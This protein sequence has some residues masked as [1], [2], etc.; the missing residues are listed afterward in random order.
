MPRIRPQRTRKLRGSRAR[1]WAGLS[2]FAQGLL[3]CTA[4]ESSADTLGSVG[5]SSFEPDPRSDT[6]RRP[7]A[8][9]NRACSRTNEPSEALGST[10]NGSIDESSLLADAGRTP[11]MLRAERDAGSAVPADAEPSSANEAPLD[12]QGPGEFAGVGGEGCFVWIAELE[13]WAAARAACADWG[14]ALARV[15]SAVEDELLADHMSADS[16]IGANDRG[17]EG[18]VVWDD[19]GVLGFTNWAEAQPDNSDDG[20]DCVEKLERN[21][22]WNDARCDQPNA[23]F[24]ERP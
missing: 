1:S 13:T 19:A 6:N 15:D 4:Y 21:A 9:M 2:A 24:C 11:P 23:Y 10:T 5:G 16:W 7:C 14:G 3:A 22:Q 20:E 8:V 17:V 12:C 18:R